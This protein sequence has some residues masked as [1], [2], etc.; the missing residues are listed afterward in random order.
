MKRE[1]VKDKQTT[2]KKLKKKQQI[3]SD[4]TNILNKKHKHY[5]NEKREENKK[6]QTN[7]K[8]T[9]HKKTKKHVW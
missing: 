7:N 4:G 8:Q 1:E 5:S 9:K 2:I 3:T 6:Q